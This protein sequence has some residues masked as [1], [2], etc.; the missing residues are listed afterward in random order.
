YIFNNDGGYTLNYEH[1]LQFNTYHSFHRLYG[2][3]FIIYDPQY[4]TLKV[5]RNQTTMADS[6]LIVGPENALNEV[7][8][9]W[10]AN[11]GAYN[12]IREMV[13]T[14]T[15]LEIGAVSELSYTINSGK[16]LIGNVQIV[17]PLRINVPI[18][19]LEIIFI[20]PNGVDFS[21][22][23]K[24]NLPAPEIVTEQGKTVYKYNLTEVPAVDISSIADRSFIPHII[25]QTGTESLSDILQRIAP[26]AGEE[27]SI[28]IDDFDT[29]LD[30][31]KEIV[32]IRTINVPLEFQLFPL[33]TPDITTKRN[34]GTPLEKAVLFQ[35]RL[36][37]KGIGSAILF[38]APEALI[39]DNC[40]NIGAVTDIFV[41]LDVD[42]TLC[43]LSPVYLHKSNPI[44][45]Q[46]YV[47]IASTSQGL[48][49]VDKKLINK[50][51]VNAK[52]QLKYDKK[53][54]LLSLLGT[55]EVTI[56]GAGHN[57]IVS[58]EYQS[59]AGEIVSAKNAQIK[60]SK[61]KDLHSYSYELEF[62]DNN[63]NGA[64]N[65][66]KV[67]LPMTKSGINSWN[68]G[69]LNR[70][71][72]NPLR[73]PYGLQQEEI[74]TINIPKGAIPITKEIS[75][76]RETT[77]GEL[78]LSLTYTKTHIVVT[79]KISIRSSLILPPDYETFAEMYNLWNSD[80]T[81]EFY[82]EVK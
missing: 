66:Y 39:D 40:A 42:K 54:K 70:N 21:I 17:E 58:K 8:P 78:E 22:S 76:K 52:L 36:S 15:G 25:A 57:F 44:D 74:Y 10:A 33:Q 7:L 77:F 27:K 69:L 37:D 47:Y 62:P 73:L 71:Q 18:D 60:N 59:K 81:K 13:V 35:K 30:I 11:S 4:Q 16:P 67:E 63:L 43:A 80:K 20:V 19:N 3:T 12:H 9:S 23:E 64:H 14:H 46:G 28:S 56:R 31:Q 61:E 79:R 38:K 41:L 48:K 53:Q 6:K 45:I 32:N 29:V 2:E 72:A 68:L 49:R 51:T 5:T 50:T 75:E 24:A 82:I 55:G 65:V 1:K 34:S 26:S